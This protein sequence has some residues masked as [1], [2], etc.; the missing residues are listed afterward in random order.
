[1]KK[2]QMGTSQV[3]APELVMGSF[4]MGGGTSWQDTTRDDQE[5]VEFIQAA[6]EIGVCGIDT[7]PVYGTGRS[8]RIVGQAIKPDREN[9]YLSTKCCMQWRNAAGTFQYTRDGVSVYSNFQKGSL[10]QDVEDSLRRLD[11]DYIDLM[12]VHR[13]PPL[14]AIPEVMDALETLKQRGL[15]RAAG[16]S[17]AGLTDHPVEALETCLKYGEL[18][19]VQESASLLNKKNLGDY[20]RACEKHQV[21]FQNYS[22]LE[23]GA[24]A[25]KLIENVTSMAGDNRSKYKWFQPQWI[26]RLNALTQSL[27]PIASRYG[28]TVSVLCLAWLRA[29]SPAV[30]LLVG[31]RKLASIQDTLKVL[32]VKL[33]PEDMAEMSHLSDVANGIV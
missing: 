13:C 20:L 27:Q 23:K 16:L 17:N 32:D 1:M 6:H 26:P 11:T 12:I 25:G 33:D 3:F 7:A 10:I 14:E 5:L 30:N 18:D 8:E 31:A 2:M 29:Q 28:C 24:L 21:T 9:Y 4:G 22:G 15:I 19:L